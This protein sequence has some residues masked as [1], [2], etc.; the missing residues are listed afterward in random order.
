MPFDFNIAYQQM[1]GL[2][3]RRNFWEQKRAEA[4]RLI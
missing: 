4:F 2:C 1:A 3:N